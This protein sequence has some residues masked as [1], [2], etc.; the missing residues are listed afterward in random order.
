MIRSDMFVSFEHILY[1]SNFRS[2]DFIQVHPMGYGKMQFSMLIGF[3]RCFD[4]YTPDM[5]MSNFWVTDKNS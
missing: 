2:H 1:N 5:D 4:Y 3:D